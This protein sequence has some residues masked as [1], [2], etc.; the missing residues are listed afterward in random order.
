[1]APWT[2]RGVAGVSRQLALHTSASPSS[3][4]APTGTT[5]FTTTSGGS[6]PLM[7]APG[8]GSCISSATCRGLRDALPKS[9]VRSSYRAGADGACV[10]QRA[11][12][13]RV[14]LATGGAGTREAPQA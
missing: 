12:L 4:G 8:A 9:L 5:M 7:P 1:M 10:F 6:R 2:V 13:Y 3:D 14:L 11:K